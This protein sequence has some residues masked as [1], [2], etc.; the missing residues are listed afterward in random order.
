MSMQEFVDVLANPD[1]AL[2]PQTL[3]KDMLVQYAQKFYPAQMEEWEFYPDGPRVIALY[4][5]K[6]ISPAFFIE[7]MKKRRKAIG[8]VPACKSVEVIKAAIENIKEIEHDWK[9]RSGEQEMKSALSI[10]KKS[11]RRSF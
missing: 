7:L 10:W 1:N 5:I 6:N 11:I 2:F 8:N 9:Q 4:E 3:P